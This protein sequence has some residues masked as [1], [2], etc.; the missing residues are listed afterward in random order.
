MDA[1]QQSK[2]FCEWLE[3]YQKAVWHRIGYSRSIKG[4]KVYET[5][6]TQNFVFELA[7]KNF[8]GVKIYES[9]DENKNGSDLLINIVCGKFSK[10]LAVQA[11]IVY[12]NEKF[13]MINHVVGKAGV[14]QIDLLINYANANHMHPAY[15]FYGYKKLSFNCDYGIGF[16]DAKTIKKNYFSSP[17]TV[18]IPEMD[19]LITG[20]FCKPA[21]KVLCCTAVTEI[22]DFNESQDN[23]VDENIWMNFNGD[24]ENNEK[25]KLKGD[26]DYNFNPAY[27]IKVVAA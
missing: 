12:S 3:H 16:A 19:E 10:K 24:F 21:H 8:S 1:C 18:E 14:Q 15:M 23:S 26:D 6:I 22:F 13:P 5:V 2:D 17:P 11:K 25:P 27:L 7:L 20:G 9:R 4:M